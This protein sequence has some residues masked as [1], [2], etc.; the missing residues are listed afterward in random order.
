[1][2]YRTLPLAL[3]A[4]STLFA[5]ADKTLPIEKTSDDFVEIAATIL[6]KEDIAKQ[7]GSDLG[8]NIVVLRVTVR[9]VSDKP[10]KIDYDDFSLFDTYVGDRSQP[11]EASQ[12]AGQG[13]LEITAADGSHKSGIGFGMGPM[14]GGATPD[15]NPTLSN[16]R[17]K[18]GSDA[19]HN[20][21]EDT[22]KKY[23]L[24][25]TSVTDPVTGLLYFQMDGKKI[26]PKNLELSYKSQ[27]GRLALRFPK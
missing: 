27:S 8:G 20:P 2:L 7:F 10:V 17:V 5:S 1:M 3:V 13:A 4:V 16:S 12:I 22:L 21:L 23:A 26:K 14:M 25:E 24:P 18:S 9:P 15:Y 19:K 11:Y 6:P